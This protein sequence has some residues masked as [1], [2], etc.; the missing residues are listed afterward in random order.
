LPSG[1]SETEIKKQKR[2]PNPLN[3]TCPRSSLSFIDMGGKRHSSS[4]SSSS[5]SGSSSDGGRHRRRRGKGGC[6]SF[7]RG[8]DGCCAGAGGLLLLIVIIGIIFYAFN[9]SNN[10][11]TAPL[12]YSDGSVK[13]YCYVVSGGILVALPDTDPATDSDAA[14]FTMESDSS[15]IQKVH[16]DSSDQHC[17]DNLG[18]GVPTVGVCDGVK[19]QWVVLPP[20]PTSGGYGALMSVDATPGNGDNMCLAPRSDSMVTNTINLVTGGIRAAG[21]QKCY[22]SQGN[23]DPDVLIN[24]S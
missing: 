12:R 19:E 24:I 7:G 17:L 5:D 13:T 16:P 22:D 1:F 8:R 20:T 18:D 15:G 14:D 3:T 6:G 10:I 2:A 11:C 23:L 4:D 9:S 21:F